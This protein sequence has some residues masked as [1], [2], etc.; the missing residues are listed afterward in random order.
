MIFKCRFIKPKE[1]EWYELEASS[2]EQAVNDF[3]EKF[4]RLSGLG[5]PTGLIEPGWT[6]QDPET[7]CCTR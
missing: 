1:S 7:S 3:H 5:D 2:L 6:Y 4:H